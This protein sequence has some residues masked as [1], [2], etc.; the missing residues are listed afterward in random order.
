MKPF[1]VILIIYAILGILVLFM[2][3]FGLVG[4]TIIA[5]ASIGNGTFETIG[6]VVIYALSAFVCVYVVSILIVYNR[7]NKINILYI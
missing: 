6:V 3:I 5:I 2:S 4:S 1:K 7:L